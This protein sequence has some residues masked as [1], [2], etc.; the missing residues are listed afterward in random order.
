MA[1][2]IQSIEKIKAWPVLRRAGFVLE[3]FRGEDGRVNCRGAAHESAGVLIYKNEESAGAPWVLSITGENL[4][5]I[6]THK[7]GALVARLNELLPG[8]FPVVMYTKDD[9]Q[10]AYNAG[11][12]LKEYEWHLAEFH[13]G[14]NCK[15][16]GDDL[17]YENFFEWISGY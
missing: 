14:E 8:L 4:E 6:E 10:A 7:G 2:T 17:Y 12:K 11:V 3:S 5:V 16:G 1:R 15:C 9:M 13:T